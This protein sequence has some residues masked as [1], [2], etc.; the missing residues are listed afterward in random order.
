MT[1]Q[2]GRGGQEFK[3]EVLTKIKSLREIWPNGNIQVDGGIN[4][5][6]AQQAIEAGANLICAGTYIFN[7]SS[8]A[9]GD[10][11]KSKDIK[12]AIESLKK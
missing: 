2:P 1:V 7:P 6:T 9:K 3:D 4:L 11:V 12:Q 5:E 10:R 8:L